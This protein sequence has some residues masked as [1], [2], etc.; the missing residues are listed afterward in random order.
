[1]KKPLLVASALV[2]AF[3]SLGVISPKAY[4]TAQTCTWTGGG[5]DSKF[6]TA[7]NWSNC[8]SSVPQAGDIISLPYISGS[9]TLTLTNDLSD[10]TA[11]GGLILNGGTSPN[12]TDYTIDKLAFGDGAVITYTSGYRINISNTVTSTGA[13]TLVNTGF[14]FVPTTKD[15]TLAPTDLTYTNVSA[16]CAG[17]I[18]DYSL[19]IKPTGAVTV[20][21]GSWYGMSGTESSVSVA[22]GGGVSLP[23]GTYGGTLTFNGGGATQGSVCGTSMSM[24]GTWAGDTTLSGTINLNGGDIILSTSKKLTITGTLNGTGNKIVLDSQSA[25]SLIN[26]AAVNNS[27][28]PGGNQTIDM[29]EVAAVEDSQP[30]ATLQVNS[31]EILTFDGVRNNVYVSNKSVLKGNG[32]AKGQLYVGQG[33][34]VAP[35]HSP[36]CLTS[37]TLSLY[38]EYQFELGGTDPC[39]G[40][41]QLKVLNASGSSSAVTI[42]NTTAIL[43]TSRYNG[44][45]P[46]QGDE[47]VIIDQAGDS[48]VSGAFKDLPEGATFTQNG[49]VFKISYVGGDGNDVTLTVQNSPTAP[50]TG[51]QLL[52]ANPAL[53]AVGTVIAFLA[54]LG[55]ARRAKQQR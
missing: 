40:Y 21:T 4:A 39:D 28:T 27:A 51:V 45:T 17:G 32:V 20:G 13:L 42:D 23:A 16:V 7:A 30:T 54:L 35:G 43:T 46:E 37:D 50:D 53:I 34:V 9:S 5:S 18:N 41:D 19:Y 44:Y 15:I 1:M 14:P 52:K 22:A 11:L 36:G 47:F 49:I 31:N 48:A 10:P 24:G 29:H 55:L 26:N 2:L 33:G 38:G 12:I 3:S 6:S 8:N 25:G